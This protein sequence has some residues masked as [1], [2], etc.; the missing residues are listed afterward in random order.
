MLRSKFPPKNASIRL[1]LVA[2]HVVDPG[3]QHYCKE[4]TFFMGWLFFMK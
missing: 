1:N 3:K 4:E 2:D